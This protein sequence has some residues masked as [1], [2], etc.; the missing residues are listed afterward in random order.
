MSAILV[1]GDTQVTPT[2]GVEESRRLVDV[3]GVHAIVGPL[4][5]SV[6]IAVAESVS[7]PAGIPTISPSATSPSV[8]LA[9]DSGFLFR[10]TISDAAQAP[11]L[12]EMVSAIGA[13]NVAVLYLNDAYGQGLADGFAASFAGTATLVSLEDGQLSYL[14]E[15]RQAAGGGA[16]YLV[17]ISFPAQAKVCIRQALV[18]D[19]FER[20]FFVDG[21][22]SEELIAEIGAEFLEGSPGN[23]PSLPGD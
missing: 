4:S 8:T 15:L 16:E 13:D 12:A 23:R 3:A 10:S 18:H 14:A 7:G 5:S 21:T 22:K 9:N 17:A 20:F 6:T 1:T 19:L 2:V 11:V